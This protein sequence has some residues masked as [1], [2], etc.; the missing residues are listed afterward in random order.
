MYSSEINPSAERG[1]GP[2]L[3][4]GGLEQ[5]LPV[6]QRVQSQQYRLHKLRDRKRHAEEFAPHRACSQQRY[7]HRK[8]D[9]PSRKQQRLAKS[10]AALP[11]NT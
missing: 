6:P 10:Q 3:Q 8:R 2:H 11:K 9:S 1:P 5:I 4:R 7:R